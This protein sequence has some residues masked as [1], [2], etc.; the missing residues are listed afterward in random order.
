MLQQHAQ[1]G[2][3]E[4]T[5]AAQEGRARHDHLA[6]GQHLQFLPPFAVAPGGRPARLL[7]SQVST[8]APAS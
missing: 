4:Q 1:A 6:A 7:A 2:V 8:A 5:A 3:G